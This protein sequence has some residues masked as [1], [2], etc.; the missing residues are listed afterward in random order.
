MKKAS[1]G[2]WPSSTKASALLDDLHDPAGS[3][4]DQHRF[5]VDHSIAIVGYAV[6][7]M[8]ISSDSDPSISARPS[9]TGENAINFGLFQPV[10]L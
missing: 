4:I 2:D 5:V 1:L 8:M 9:R 10:I 6:D 7:F 3:G